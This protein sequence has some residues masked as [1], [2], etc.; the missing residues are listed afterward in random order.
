MGSWSENGE[1]EKRGKAGD[2]RF[3][4]DSFRGDSGPGKGEEPSGRNIPHAAQPGGE[5]VSDGEG[6][7]NGRNEKIQEMRCNGPKH[8]AGV[9]RSEAAGL[10]L[11]GG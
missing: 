2:G 4:G 3:H 10:D 5:I 11:A 9:R 8:E 6:N 7:R 1:R